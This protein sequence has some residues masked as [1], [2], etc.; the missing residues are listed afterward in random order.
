MK[1]SKTLNRRVI[2]AST[3]RGTTFYKLDIDTVV[4]SIRSNDGNLWL[5][6]ALSADGFDAIDFDKNL[7]GSQVIG[8][9]LYLCVTDGQDITVQD[10]QVD[11]ESALS[12]YSIEELSSY[13]VEGNAKIVDQY[14]T[15]YELKPI[16]FDEG[17]LWLLEEG[18]TFEDLVKDYQEFE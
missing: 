14:I 7:F 10:K 18:F 12:T 9:V 11:P 6:Y 8:D 16:D 1:T 5:Y 17:A 15:T 2:Y 13:I 4:D 3:S